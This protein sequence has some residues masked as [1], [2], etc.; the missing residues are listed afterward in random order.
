MYCQDKGS[1]ASKSKEG[2]LDTD[3]HFGAF[4][5]SSRSHVDVSAHRS[6]SAFSAA[7]VRACEKSERE[8]EGK[9]NVRVS[10]RERE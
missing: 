3:V 6:L 2:K 8:R 7:F 9:K 5:F 1:T 4:S 10:E